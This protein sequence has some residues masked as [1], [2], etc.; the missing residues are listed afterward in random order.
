MIPTKTELAELD[1][2]TAIE[3]MGWEPRTVF[4]APA[5]L[6][7]TPGN[8]PCEMVREDWHP[9][10][11]LAQAQ[12]VVAAMAGWRHTVVTLKNGQIQARFDRDIHGRILGAFA[13]DR[14]EPLAICR[15]A[16]AAL[17]GFARL[18]REPVDAR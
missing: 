5:Y 16:L 13:D 9:S 8:P 14:T 2:R 4:G 1:R 18:V 11:N 7:V 15:A 17:Q 12:E 6:V 10:A 3:V